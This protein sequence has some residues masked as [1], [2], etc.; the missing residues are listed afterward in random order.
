M[1]SLLVGLG[2]RLGVRSRYLHSL[3]AVRSLTQNTDDLHYVTERQAKRA[4]RS[5]IWNKRVNESNGN[6]AF[7]ERLEKDAAT[8]PAHTEPI[9]KTLFQSYRS[10]LL[11]FSSSTAL[12]EQY[13]NMYGD[14]RFG[15]I[16]EDLDAF[17][18][19]A[20]YIH[21]DGL[22]SVR[23]MTIV[24]ASCD[25]IEI[26]SPISAS[27]DLIMEGCVTFVGRSSMVVRVEVSSLYPDGKEVPVL[28]AA[29]TLVAKDKATQKATPVNTLQPKTELEQKLYDWGKSHA[30]REKQQKAAD[31]PATPP[32]PE[33]SAL[34]HSVFNQQRSRRLIFAEAPAGDIP[35]SKTV[36]ENTQIMFPQ[37]KNIH[38]KIF[39][40]FLM[41]QAYELAWASAH[42]F[43]GARPIFRASDDIQFRK[44][45]PIGCIVVFSSIVSYVEAPFIHVAVNADVVNPASGERDT[46]NVFT[47]TFRSD[48]PLTRKVHPHS[49]LEGVT[50]LHGR[51]SHGRVVQEAA[52]Q[53]MFFTAVSDKTLLAN[54]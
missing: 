47:F 42:L 2:R 17:A 32:S 49:Y 4:H 52:E 40:G 46:T 54:K 38:H 27:R 34:L 51:R 8:I 6:A 44:P 30:E 37:E 5:F 43:S 13:V 3:S 19:E 53:P 14:L 33:D 18:A 10:Y 7:A 39:G 15:K 12:R 31:A 22:N 35:M 16:M 45:V 36:F 11:P 9:S 21:A 24:T 26:L 25:R 50:Y 29:F 1:A 20:A 41:R 28:A 48:V 23:P